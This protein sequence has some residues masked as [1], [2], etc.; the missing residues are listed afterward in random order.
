MVRGRALGI[1]TWIYRPFL[2]YAVHNGPDATYR[3]L[4]QPLVDKALL[5]IGFYI[6]GEPSQ[7][8]HHGTWLSIRETT[9]QVLCMIGASISGRIVM[10]S[11]WRA[12]ARSCIDRLRYWDQEA[13]EISKLTQMLESYL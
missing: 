10:P 5:Y 1:K 13:P 8:R 6:Q 2:Y 11:D 4:V 9:A 7:H 12:I 3:S